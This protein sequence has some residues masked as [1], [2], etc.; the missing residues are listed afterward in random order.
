MA[1]DPG[2]SS[3][4]RRSPARR[5]TR[6]LAHLTRVH[7]SSICIFVSATVLVSRC[8]YRKP[9]RRGERLREPPRPMDVLSAPYSARQPC[10][11]RA[12]C[13]ACA[14]CARAA[15]AC[16]RTGASECLSLQTASPV[17]Q[18][19][20][21]SSLSPLRSAGSFFGA[22]LPWY[23]GRGHFGPLMSHS[24]PPTACPGGLIRCS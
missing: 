9:A 17:K 14:A 12:V 16:A 19:R 11:G 13:A 5:P 23:L 10:S 15:C 1:K 6:R 20:S 4:P 21:D 2:D 3:R 24:H 18:Q 22:R 7:Q 8:R